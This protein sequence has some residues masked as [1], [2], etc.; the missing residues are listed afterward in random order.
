MLTDARLTAN[1]ANARKSTGPRTAAGKARSALNRLQDGFRA[2]T[3]ILP[4]EDPA[5]YEELLDELTLGIEPVTLVETRCVREM[6]DAEW[7]LRR[8]RRRMAELIETG[9]AT[10]SPA[11]PG[12]AGSASELGQSTASASMECLVRYETLFLNRFA[13][14]Q[15]ECWRVQAE[16]SRHPHPRPAS[17]TNEPNTGAIPSIGTEPAARKPRGTVATEPA[18][19]PGGLAAVVPISGATAAASPIE[20]SHRAATARRDVARNAPCPCGSGHKYKR[21]CG[22]TAPPQLGGAKTTE[23]RQNR[24]SLPPA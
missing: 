8:V 9:N 5:E 16:R 3:V 13:R 20:P 24:R 11:T 2:C 21:C 23:E 4:S 19:E 22:I 17:P 6:A 1:R 14:A 12:P 10:T 7:R 18:H 15:R